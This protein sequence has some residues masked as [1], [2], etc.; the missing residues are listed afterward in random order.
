MKNAII[1]ISTFAAGAAIGSFVT[2]R[3]LEKKYQ[4]DFEQEVADVRE[5]YTKK[6]VDAYN[7]LDEEE[8]SEL[9]QTE[10]AKANGQAHEKKPKYVKPAYHDYTKHSKEMDASVVASK[11][12]LSELVR[13]IGEESSKPATDEC[14]LIRVIN[15]ADYINN[16]NGFEKI[17]LEYFVDDDALV[18][19]K[20]DLMNEEERH[21]AIGDLNLLNFE[22]FKG[23]EDSGSIFVMNEKM[24]VLF[25]ILLNPSSYRKEILG[26]DDD[27][28]Y[29]YEDDR[30]SRE[31]IRR[32][33]KLGDE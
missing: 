22:E 15:E 30:P 26:I 23:D 14:S 20:Q 1:Y 17:E 31:S 4:E 12:E 6:L 2:Y 33:R 3:V 9:S 10:W 32:P 19:D 21:N 18:D 29:M 24:R 11:P 13:E 16:Y 8:D 25:E 28:D 27:E 7:T 5:A